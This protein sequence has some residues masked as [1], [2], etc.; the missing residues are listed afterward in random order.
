R[1]GD[2]G[3]GRGGLRAG[4]LDEEEGD[5]AVANVPPDEAASVD[6][7]LIGGAREAAPER[8]VA[9]CGQATCERG[10]SFEVREQDRRRAPC[11]IRSKCRRST[12]AATVARIAIPAPGFEISAVPACRPAASWT[13]TVVV[14]ASTGVPTCIPCHA[15]ESAGDGSTGD[16]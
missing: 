13:R 9:S 4:G 5:H 7:A 1:G 14:R 12:P 2:A 11:R 8:E 3:A 15:N 16:S 6:D 10:R